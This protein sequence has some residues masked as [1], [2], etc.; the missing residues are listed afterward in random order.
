MQG[1]L[2]G[3]E[4]FSYFFYILHKHEHDAAATRRR[5]NLMFK[6]FFCTLLQIE[7]SM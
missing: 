1:W 4:C 2:A 3:F 5:A 7:F 6:S